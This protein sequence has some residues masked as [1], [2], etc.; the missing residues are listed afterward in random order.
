MTLFFFRPPAAARGTLDANKESIIDV[1]SNERRW[2]VRWGEEKTFKILRARIQVKALKVSPLPRQHNLCGFVEMTLFFIRPPAVASVPF[3]AYKE[4]KIDVISNE[5]RWQLQWSEEKTFIIRRPSIQGKVLKVSPH[6]LQH[7]LLV[8]VE[9]TLFFI[10]RR[11]KRARLSFGSPRKYM[12]YFNAGSGRYLIIHIQIE[13]L[14][15]F[16]QLRVFAGHMLV[17]F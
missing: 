13:P 8:F 9:M 4:S 15:Q 10:T 1:I 3:D 6:P 7:N 16:G 12:I 14:A 17:F 11:V 5:R 2:E